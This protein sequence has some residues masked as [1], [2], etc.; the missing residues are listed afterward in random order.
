MK[1]IS[2]A[3]VERHRHFWHHV[4]WLRVANYIYMVMTH[5][6]QYLLCSCLFVFLVTSYMADLGTPR[7]YVSLGETESF[8]L[9]ERPVKNEP[10]GNRNRDVS[11]K[12]ERLGYL[13]VKTVIVNVDI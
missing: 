2:G 13:A 9:C 1:R 10:A 6:G 8:R 7:G 12:P 11:D 4:R 5:C 3:E